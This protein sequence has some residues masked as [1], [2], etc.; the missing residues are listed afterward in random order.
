MYVPPDCTIL[1]FTAEP[2]VVQ[3]GDVTVTLSW[4]TANGV[5]VE[6]LYPGGDSI[7][8]GANDEFAYTFFEYGLQSQTWGLRATC[9][10]GVATASVTVIYDPG[11]TPPA[12]SCSLGSFSGAPN[13]AN[14]GSLVTLN[15][16]T[17][18]SVSSVMLTPPIG[19]AFSVA[20]SG[21][22]QYNAGTYDPQ[23]EAWALDVACADN[24]VFNGGVTIEV[25]PLAP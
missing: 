17:T 20:V 9:S 3:N 15:W 1:S 25:L 12:A 2:S 24:S 13:P 6:L 7:T 14:T 18:G 23:F 21:A 8:V 19:P 11:A 10:T 22:F 5:S 16:T 4:Q